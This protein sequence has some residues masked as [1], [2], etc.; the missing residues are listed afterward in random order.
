MIVLYWK[1]NGIKTNVK[2]KYAMH[3]IAK[4]VA[5]VRR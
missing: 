1:A 5:M 3:R 2:E 4:K